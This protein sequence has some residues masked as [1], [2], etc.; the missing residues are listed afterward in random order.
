MRLKVAYFV[1]ADEDSPVKGLLA[2][3]YY[4][5]KRRFVLPR[6]MTW[7]NVPVH[8]EFL[9]IKSTMSGRHGE[10]VKRREY[11]VSEDWY[12]VVLQYGHRRTYSCD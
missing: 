7:C 10:S 6:W 8:G 2:Y 12:N 3:C 11:V 1:R 5:F 4:F 9:D